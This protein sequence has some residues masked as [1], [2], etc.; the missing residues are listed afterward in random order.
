MTALLTESGRDTPTR[1]HANINSCGSSTRSVG[2]LT[3]PARNRTTPMCSWGRGRIN[4]CNRLALCAF[5]VWD[6]NQ[7]NA[8]RTVP[9]LSDMA[10]LNQGLIDRR[11]RWAAVQALTFLRGRGVKL[12]PDG[13]MV[14]AL[15]NGW[16]STGPEDLRQTA[17]DLNKGEKLQFTT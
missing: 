3:P 12:E 15:R 2:S 11:E 1:R 8:K 9:G 4:Q 14:E 10:V 6:A 7:R 13:L 17:I 16:G 5:S